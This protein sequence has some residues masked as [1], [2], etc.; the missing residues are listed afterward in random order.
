MNERFEIPAR[1]RNTGLGLMLFG[2][3]VLIIGAFTLLGGDHSDKTRFWIVLLHNSVFFLLVTVASIF[4]QA[5][6]SLAQGAW[7]VAYKRVPEA[8]GANVW[9]FGLI[10]MIVMF[11]I[12]FGVNIDGHNPIYHWVHPGD[13]KILQGKSSFLNA[14]MFV[15]FTVVTVALWSF[16]GFKFRSLSLQQEGA[17]KNSTKIYWATAVWG[18]LF[19]LVYALTQMSIAPWLW[20]MS[21]DAHWYSTM[22][23][24]YTFASAFVSGLSV[25]LLFVIALKNQGNLQLVNKEHVHDLGKLMFAFSIFWT[26]V[27]FAQ[28]MLIWYGNI[29]EETTY[30]KIRQQGPYGM[31]WYSV[32][33]INFVMPILILM[34]RPSK[35]NYFTVCFMALAIIFGH[36]LDFYIMTMPGPLG[37]HWHLSW[38]E[39]G[40]FAGFVGILIFTV[41]RTLASASLV[42]NN[43][44][45]LKEA[46]LHQS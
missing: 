9:V 6:A 30:F 33:I 44:P 29:P 27:W 35:R 43:H 4:I 1:M 41:S 42:P 14:G 17:P 15:G 7:I 23:S 2:L 19:L 10:A 37:E 21:I 8:I 39:I 16:F 3:L 11:I 38:Y 32:F 24:W 34:S 45:L 22:F 18:A 20:I 25:I 13:D 31:I 28:Y 46:I 12:A 5:A 40:I 36:W 26:Y